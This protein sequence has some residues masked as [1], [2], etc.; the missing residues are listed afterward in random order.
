[1]LLEQ[2]YRSTQTILDVANAVISNNRNRTPKKL[3]TDNGQGVPV[4]VYE[5]YNEIE[6][7]AYVADEIEKLIAAAATFGPGRLCR[8]VSHQ[9]PEPRAGRGVC[10]A[11]HE[12]QAGRRHAL[13]RAQG[14]QGCAGLSAPDPQPG[15][16]RRARPHHQRAAARDRRQERRTRCATGPRAGRERVRGP[17]GHP[18]RPACVRPSCSGARCPAGRACRRSAAAPRR[19]WPTSAALL[20]DWIAQEAAGRHRSVADLLDDV[21]VQ[22]R[23]LEVLRD[24]TEEGEDRFENLQELRAVAAT[25]VQGMPDLETDRRRWQVPGRSQP[26]LRHGRPAG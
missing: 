18:P 10:A 20:E 21:L 22:S 24:G 2:N 17:A 23:Y 25:Y 11:R 7:A 3:R 13:L 14:N 19:R 6:E 5:A 16:Q 15:R 12:V 1:M 8:H 9:C 4:T 26:G